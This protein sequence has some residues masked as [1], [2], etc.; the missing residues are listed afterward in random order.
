MSKVDIVVTAKPAKEES[1]DGLFSN[2][3]MW[4]IMVV[5]LIIVLV[6]IV[7]VF[8]RKKRSEKKTWEDTIDQEEPLEKEGDVEVVE[9]PEKAAGRTPRTPTKTKAQAL[10]DHVEA[11]QKE[12]CSSCGLEMVYDEDIESY[13]C[14]YCDVFEEE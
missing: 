7:L 1:E 6:I 10:P 13:Q 4:I 8:Q 12:L 9:K 3:L 2:M 14:R 11:P 5:V